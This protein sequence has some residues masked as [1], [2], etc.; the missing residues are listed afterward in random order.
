MDKILQAL[1]AHLDTHPAA[2][3]QDAVKFIYQAC[4][5]GGHMIADPHASYTCLCAES[6][7][8]PEGRRA[9]LTETLG[10][11]VR[12]DLSALRFLSPETMNAMFVASAEDAP[13]DK[14]YFLALLDAFGADSRFDASEKRAYLE[15]YRAAGCPAVHHSER[16]RAAYAP[17]YRVVKKAYVQ[18]LD[19]FRAIDGRLKNGGRL[20]AAIDGLCGS[21]KTTLA[22]LLQTVYDCNVFHA[23]DFYLPVPLRTPERYQTPGGNV[24]WER[25]LDEVL[26]PLQTGRP[27]SYRLFDCGIMDYNGTVSVEPKAL[28]ILEGSYSMHP[29]LAGYYDLRI[30]L[31]TP[32]DVQSAR[33]LKRNGPERHAMF[34]AKWIPLENAYFASYP[35]EAESDLVFTT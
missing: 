25:I 32:P 23:D 28:S 26:R 5:G 8:L 4:F 1:D 6:A 11:Y 9:P 21:G 10:G 33:I 2:Q 20:T 13:Q 16:Y 3:I 31:K 19:A 35:V 12:L 14:T 15:A 27:F 17:A 30:F 18:F 34:V 22:A 24:H 29:A 7:A